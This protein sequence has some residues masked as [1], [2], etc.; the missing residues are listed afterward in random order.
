[1][2]ADPET[3]TTQSGVPVANFRIAVSRRFK[4]ADGKRDSD[5]LDVQAWRNTAEYIGK[6]IHKGDRVAVEGSIQTRS[7]EAKDGSKRWV[8][9]IIADSV[10]GLSSR[11]NNGNNEGSGEAE[12]GKLPWER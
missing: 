7:Y 9:E 12:D 5:F 3:R 10:E 4:N 11:N 6:Y 2:V 8:T 1:M